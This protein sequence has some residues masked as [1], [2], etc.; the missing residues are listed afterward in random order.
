LPFYQAKNRALED[1][2]K[3]RDALEKEKTNH[4]EHV[5]KVREALD[6]EIAAQKKE[7]EAFKNKEE[8]FS[9]SAP[10]TKKLLSDPAKLQKMVERLKFEVTTLK[11]KQKKEP[12]TDILTA[13]AEV[14]DVKKELEK[15]KCQCVTL[16]KEL[17]DTKKKLA[18]ETKVSVA[19]HEENKNWKARSDAA[20][21]C[22]AV[23]LK[24]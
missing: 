7:I 8:E 3:A 17:E 11:A 21:L 10:S 1:T 6:A 20:D 13:A 24:D 16:Q 19:L 12:G 5:K 22:K 9:T 2:Q 15:V 18:S 4:L 14:N 23:D